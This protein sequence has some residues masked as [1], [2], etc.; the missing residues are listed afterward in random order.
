MR[1]RLARGRLSC[2]LNSRVHQE[3]LAARRRDSGSAALAA[4]AEMC[5]GSR[6]KFGRTRWPPAGGEPALGSRKKKSEIRPR[7]LGCLIRGRGEILTNEA[8]TDGV[9]VICNLCPGLVLQWATYWVCG[10][11]RW[12]FEMRLGLRKKVPKSDSFGERPPTVRRH[13]GEFVLESPA[14]RTSRK[15]LRGRSRNRGDC[16][17]RG[18]SGPQGLWDGTRLAE[19]Y[20]RFFLSIVA[21]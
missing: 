17:R 2:F 19:E 20:E 8:N 12:L 9:S 4:D 11:T 13:F 14:A 18:A 21:G 7:D 10:L 1:A 16:S 5:V 3:L 15:S 6:P